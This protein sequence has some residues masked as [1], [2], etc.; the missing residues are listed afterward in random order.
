M[1]EDNPNEVFDAAF[2]II[3][4]ELDP[5][6]INSLLEINPDNV[7]KKGETNNRKS[8]SGKIIVQ[9]PLEKP[10]ISNLN[11]IENIPLFHT[12]YFISPLS[13]KK[14]GLFARI[15]DKPSIVGNL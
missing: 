2:R 8:K 4:D 15:A 10:S 12:A 11:I 6:Y 7:H 1:L 14:E 13:R 5:D 3:G 9:S